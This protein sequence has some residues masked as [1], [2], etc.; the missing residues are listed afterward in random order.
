[1][2]TKELRGLTDA[3]LQQKLADNKTELF[4]LRIQKSTGRIERPLRIRI[5]R[6]EVAT[7]LTLMKQRGMN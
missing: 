7:V 2:K 3:E 5:L 6:R 4:N 1:M